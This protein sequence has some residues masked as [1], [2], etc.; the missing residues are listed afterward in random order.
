MRTA[1]QQKVTSFGTLFSTL[2]HEFC[3]HLDMTV[4]GFEQ[5]PH[6][7]GFYERAACLYHHARGTP[8]KP[9]RWVRMAG[10]AYRVDWAATNR[11]PKRDTARS[12]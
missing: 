10:G 11:L 7:K 4:L 12:R 6:T 1:V 5:T 2:C 3:H 9:L 8:Y